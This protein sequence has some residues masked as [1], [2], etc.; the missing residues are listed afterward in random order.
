[1]A[2]TIFERYGG[3]AAI[4]RVVSDFYDR[5]LDSP[6]ISHHFERVDMR[7]L[8]DHQARFISAVTGGPAS[9]TD[10]HLRRTHERLG[11]TAEEFREMVDLLTET[12]E[13]FGWARSDIAFVASEL[14]RR[15]GVIVSR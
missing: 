10:E 15:Q 12:L 7:R 1:M 11:V 9:Y 4:R 5:V 8:L 14:R 13:D 6:V 3:F 2:D